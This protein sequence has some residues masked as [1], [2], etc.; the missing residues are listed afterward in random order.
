MWQYWALIRFDEQLTLYWDK[1]VL[2]LSSPEF[3]IYGCKDKNNCANNRLVDFEMFFYGWNGFGSGISCEHE[4][5]F[6]FVC[7]HCSDK[8]RHVN[9]SAFS[10]GDCDFLPYFLDALYI[11]WWIGKSK[12]ELGS[13]KYLAE[14]SNWFIVAGVSGKE[15]TWWYSSVRFLWLSLLRYLKHCGVAL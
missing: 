10:L 5:D 2:G 13:G 8:T 9:M 11:K 6:I 1:I 14:Q 4:I 15:Y 7:N 12:I 3:D